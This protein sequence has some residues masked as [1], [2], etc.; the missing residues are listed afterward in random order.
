MHSY[1]LTD[2]NR[3]NRE[4][5]AL[6]LAQKLLQIEHP[7]TS[8][9]DL[10]ILEAQEQSSIS[11]ESARAIRE[12][13]KNKP[14]QAAAKVV[15]VNQAEL[16]TLEAQNALLKT[17][18]EPPGHSF[19]ILTSPHEE[20]LLPT[21]VSR[22]VLEKAD[23]KQTPRS[24]SKGSTGTSNFISL[25]KSDYRERLDF[26]EKNEDLFSQKETAIQ[27]LDSWLTQLYSSRKESN[28]F[29]LGPVFKALLEAKKSLLWSHVSARALVELCLLKIPEKLKI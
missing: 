24:S 21:V 11:I 20:L 17:L 23:K 7:L 28:L 1:L 19:I 16:L 8:H 29:S 18:E 25:L 12:F 2:P 3:E 6:A 4:Q 27:T 13:L 14:F 26:M 22:C 5:A 10:L 15:I 9:V